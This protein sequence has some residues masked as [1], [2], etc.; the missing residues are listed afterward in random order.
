MTDAVESVIKERDFGVG[1]YALLGIV[2]HQPYA[3]AVALLPAKLIR[4][5]KEQRARGATVIG[6]HERGI[7]KRVVRVVMAGDDDDPVFGPWKLGDDVVDGKLALGR[8][9]G[10]RV[11]LD[12]VAFE[13]GEDV[14]FNFFVVCAAEG[15]RA[16]GYDFFHVLE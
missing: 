14:V 11:V 13:M 5:F 10:E 8:V 9:G 1:L 16:E 7:A 6:S 2:P 4:E 3:V 12:L 15:A